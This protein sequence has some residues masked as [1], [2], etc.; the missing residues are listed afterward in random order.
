VAILNIDIMDDTII[1]TIINTL[2]GIG[3]KVS[4][5]E[6]IEVA[7]KIDSAMPGIIELMTI[8]AHNDWV[9]QAINAKGW[10]TKYAGAIKYELSDKKGE[11]YLDDSII[12]KES[13]KP[14][15][16]FAKMM[17]DGVKSWSIK[18]ALLK[19]DKAKQNSS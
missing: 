12:D 10:G 18:D 17:E 14:N 19:S 4:E 13:N 11:V 5:N 2:D 7:N 6:F 15:I 3:R 8:E 1:D 9:S 16:M